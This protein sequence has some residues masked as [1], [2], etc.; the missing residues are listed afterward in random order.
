MGKHFDYLTESVESLASSSKSI[1][2]TLTCIES[3]FGAFGE[4]TETDI[5]NLK[6]DVQG[7]QTDLRD[8]KKDFQGLKAA[9][10]IKQLSQLISD[11]LDSKLERILETKKRQAP[12]PPPQTNLAPGPILPTRISE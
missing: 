2:D 1:D 5:Q 8:L 3:Q 6:K 11:S 12:R 4:R 9:M 7:L 10:D